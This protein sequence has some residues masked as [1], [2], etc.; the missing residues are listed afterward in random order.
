MAFSSSSGDCIIMAFV[1][2]SIVPYRRWNSPSLFQPVLEIPWTK[3]S[4][5]Y[6][7]IYVLL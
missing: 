7:W 3:A 2:L 1:A 4:C 6:I 5:S